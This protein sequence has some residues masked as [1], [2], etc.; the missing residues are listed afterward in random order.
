M[1]ASGTVGERKAEVLRAVVDDHIRTGEPVGS[2][3]V[4]R[5]YR[6]GVSSATIRNDM[7][8]LTELGFL[9][10][11]HTS[12]GRIPTDSGYRFYVDTLPR[13][14]TLPRTAERTVASTLVPPPPELS[15]AVRRAAV[16]LS[17]LT[18]YGAV[19]QPPESAHVVIGGAANIVSDAS[20]Q[21]RETV[22]RLLEA[23]EDEV[24][25]VALLGALAG[26]GEVAIRIGGEIPVVALR[27]ASVVVA[28]YGPAR[29]RLGVLAVIG[30]TRM[31]YRES[32]SAVRSV[33]RHLSRAV[34]ALAG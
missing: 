11:P 7:A 34:E 1:A 29:R 33:S 17:R 26:E 31:H 28:A 19:A 23:L 4:A 9:A 8:A 3:T 10:Q 6:L 27:E 12:A 13:W 21:R 5:R 20:F 32:I 14:P 22:A 25:V 30:P 18:H 2:G 16:V 24:S 15:E